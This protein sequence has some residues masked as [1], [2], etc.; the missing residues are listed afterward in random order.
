[1]SEMNV[2]FSSVSGVARAIDNVDDEINA[3]FNE[4]IMPAVN[5]LFCTWESGGN[6]ESVANELIDDIHN[7]C[8]KARSNALREYSRFLREAV[9]EDY[10]E[11]EQINVSLADAF[12]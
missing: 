3:G 9:G 1:M 6:V 10:K 7:G 8:S 12:K 4:I 11:V 2:V 5:Q